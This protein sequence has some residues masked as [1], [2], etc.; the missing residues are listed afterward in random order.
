VYREDPRGRGTL[1]G[2]SAPPGTPI[3]SGGFRGRQK[4]SIPLV[5]GSGSEPY[6]QFW[7]T[8]VTFFD[9]RSQAFTILVKDH[10]RL[11]GLVVE[12]RDPLVRGK[13]AHGGGVSPVVSGASG[14]YNKMRGG[15]MIPIDTTAPAALR[16]FLLWSLLDRP[17]TLSVRSFAETNLVLEREGM[18]V[19]REQYD[20]MWTERVRARALEYATS[21]RCYRICRSERRAGE[22]CGARAADADCGRHGR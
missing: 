17:S 20:A 18:S 12:V 14:L 22:I 6:S 4:L 10:I 16:L 5:D 7:S 8:P 21:G 15:Q 19:S 3:Q 11:R 1:S 9:L 2:L 13:P